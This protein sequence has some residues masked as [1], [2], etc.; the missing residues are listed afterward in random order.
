MASDDCFAQPGLAWSLLGH[1]EVKEE[2][3]DNE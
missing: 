3:P 2:I 1:A